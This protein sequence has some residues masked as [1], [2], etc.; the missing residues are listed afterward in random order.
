MAGRLQQH[1]LQLCENNWIIRIDGVK[2][3]VRRRMK[4]LREEIVNE[5]SA[6]GRRV[7]NRIK[8]VTQMVRMKFE[9]HLKDVRQRNKKLQKTK[10]TTA[11]D[12]VV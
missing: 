6:V 9:R 12:M 3:I 8:W 2:G 5:A 11:H 4:D 1:K 7:K 10:K